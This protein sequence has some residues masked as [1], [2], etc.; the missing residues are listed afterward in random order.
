MIGA[1]ERRKQ[2]SGQ[3]RSVWLWRAALAA[4]AGALAG[5][6]GF[7]TAQLPPPPSPAGIQ[8]NLSLD[9]VLLETVRVETRLQAWIL[10]KVCIDGQAYWVG[11]SETSP[12]GIAPSF[13][14]AK[15]ETCGRRR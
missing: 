14:D 7:A 12:T 9:E 3:T 13:K 5:V 11:F 10:R 4:S 1:I 8:R 6:W 15:P 2:P